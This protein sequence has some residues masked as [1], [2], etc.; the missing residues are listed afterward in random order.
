MIPDTQSESDSESLIG[1][2]GPGSDSESER[3]WI[4]ANPGC[5][6]KEFG[7]V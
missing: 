6:F 4:G 5:G 7:P 3:S 1:I 2:A